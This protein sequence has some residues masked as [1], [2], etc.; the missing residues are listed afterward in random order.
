MQVTMF[1]ALEDEMGYAEDGAAI[2][3]I[4]PAINCQLSA[5]LSGNVLLWGQQLHQD[6]H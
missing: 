6:C 2:R 5:L 1:K 4:E 3:E